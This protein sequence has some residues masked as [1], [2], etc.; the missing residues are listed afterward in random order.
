VER[1]RQQSTFLALSAAALAVLVAGCGPATTSSTSSTP[2]LSSTSATGPVARTPTATPTSTRSTAPGRQLTVTVGLVDRRTRVANGYRIVLVP[3]K[4][5]NDGSW[6]VISGR[7][8][9]RYLIPHSFVPEASLL[10]GAIQVTADGHR[11][12]AVEILG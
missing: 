7:A 3:A 12:T 2:T 10:S 4:S 11:V 9:L 1:I 8:T 5:R 6:V